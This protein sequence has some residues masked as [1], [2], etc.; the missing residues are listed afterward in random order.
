MSSERASDSGSGARSSKEY[1]PCSNDV[2]GRYRFRPDVGE[3]VDIWLCAAHVN[4]YESHIV[5]TLDE[6]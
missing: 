6:E 5:E 2:A 3:P 4:E 1:V